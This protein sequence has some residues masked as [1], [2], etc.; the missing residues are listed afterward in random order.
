[1]GI[2]ASYQ[3]LGPLR[4]ACI[5]C[6][7]CCAGQQVLLV[8]DEVERILHLAADLGVMDAISGRHVRQEFGRCVF[9][10]RPAT[11]AEASQGMCGQEPPRAECILQCAA[12]AAAKPRLCR[13]YP[14]VVVQAEDG[15]RIGIDPSCAAGVLSWRS[16]SEVRVD[17]PLGTEQ[18]PSPEMQQAE[19]ALLDLSDLPGSTIAGLLEVLASGR[20]DGG[21]GLPEGMASRWVATLGEALPRLERLLDAEALSPLRPG[22]EKMLRRIPTWSAACPPPWPALAPE[23]DAWAVDVV[24]R[25]LW[26][27]LASGLPVVTGVVLLSLL[28]A[29]AAGWT[30]SSRA[31]FGWLLAAWSRLIRVQAFWL[32][33][34]PEADALV[35]LARG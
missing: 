17:Q 10:R 22:F 27:R 7:S 35:R 32:A 31:G 13:Q 14:L 20:L 5:A 16:G 30:D 19:R 8:P 11:G 12:G 21:P 29:V 18:V 24:R 33:I 15:A 4:H 6:G 2:A 9:L 1:M 34:T 28:G 23:E 26:L 25:I 3:T